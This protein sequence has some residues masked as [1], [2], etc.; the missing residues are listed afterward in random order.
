[1]LSVENISSGYGKKQVL[2][3]VTFEVDK[4]EI[5]LLTGGNGSGKSTIL[6]VIYGILPLWEG[7]VYYDSEDLSQIATSNMLKKGIVYIPQKDNYF[8]NLTIEENLK[9]SGSIYSKQDLLS[10]LEEIWKIPKLY[11]YRKKTPFNLSGGE[12]QLLAFSMGIIHNPKMILF[13][14]PISGLDNENT[15]IILDT[16][17]EFNAN[18]TGF[19]IVEHKHHSGLKFGKNIKLETGKIRV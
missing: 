17:S 10:R 19:I 1:M 7:S 9:I 16:I 8:E 3:D 11:K 5:V 4:G 6:K 14:E 2:Y 13:D 12:R 15:T 18:G